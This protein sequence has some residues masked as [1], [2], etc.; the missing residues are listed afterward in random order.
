MESVD[1]SA[2]QAIDTL[3]E[4]AAGR[5]TLRD[6]VHAVRV[7]QWAKNSLIGAGFVFAGHLREAGAALPAELLRVALAFICFCAL[8]A[9]AYV[10]NDWHDLERDRQHPLKRFRPMAAGR[11]SKQ[12]A[13][14]LVIVSLGIGVVTALLV[15]WL[16]PAARYFPLAAWFYLL[17]TLAYS[18]ALKHEVII[19]VISLAACY[20]I[21]V[22][23]GCLAIPV[24]ISPWIV[25]CTFTLAL[26]I[27]LCKRRA[28]L[29]EMGEASAGTRRVLPLYN[30]QML[31]TFIAV[32]ACLTITAYSLYTFFS[33]SPVV[34]R[35]IRDGGWPLLMMTVPFVVYGVFRYLFLAHSSPVGGE[36]E[37]M[38]RD[39]RMVINVLLF[40]AF[41]IGIS[42]L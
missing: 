12:N 18:F 20:V 19:D 8:S 39:K 11:L 35:E 25:F 15:W 33:K 14:T 23:A 13:L 40:V 28:E 31:D 22:V 42:M 10:I 17:L 3:A 38:L 9:A 21:R 1:T 6:L 29:L 34:S 16:Q 7:R 32:A 41:V 37:Q 24:W 2:A 5:L 4:S 36:P 27:G 30:L 26:F